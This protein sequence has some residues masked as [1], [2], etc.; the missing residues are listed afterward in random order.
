MNPFSEGEG[1]LELGSP[2]SE[3]SSQRH[4]HQSECILKGLLTVTKGRLNNVRGEAKLGAGL[5]SDRQQASR[6]FYGQFIYGFVSLS[7][8]FCLLRARTFTLLTTLDFRARFP[9]KTFRSARQK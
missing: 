8:D 4:L 3:D 7:F 9:Q 6:L 2:P 5:N 1:T